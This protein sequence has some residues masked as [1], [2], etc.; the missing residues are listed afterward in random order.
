MLSKP[1]SFEDKVTLIMNTGV[2]FLDF[3]L[4]LD[5]RR[6]LPG[7]FVVQESNQSLARLEYDETLPGFGD[8]RPCTS[9]SA[10]SQPWLSGI[11]NA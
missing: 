1:V 10:C 9:S 6:E 5:V 3:R 7:E 11:G 4:K 2:Q 8:A